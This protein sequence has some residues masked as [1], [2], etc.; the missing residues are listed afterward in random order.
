MKISIEK[1]VFKTLMLAGVFSCALALVSVFS[2]IPAFAHDAITGPHDGPDTTASDAAAGDVDDMK[3]F[4][5]HVRAHVTDPHYGYL[6][7]SEF[8]LALS[9]DGGVFRSGSFYMIALLPTE[10]QVIIHGADKSVEDRRLLSLEDT[11]REDLRML[12]E[13]AKADTDRD[14]VCREY[15][16]D[17]ETR[18]SC[19]LLEAG[20]LLSTG[21]TAIV[22]G[23]DVRGTDLRKLE[24]QDLPGSEVLLDSSADQVETAGDLEAQKEALKSFVHSA[25]DAYYIDFLFKGSCDFSTVPGFESFDLASLS[26]DQIKAFIPQIVSSATGGQINLLN[27]CNALRASLYRS[28]MRSEEGPWKSGSVYVFSMDDNIDVQRVLFNGLDAELE[29]KDPKT[30]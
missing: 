18:T 14:G 13:D 12:I 8:R 15:M 6:T 7:I 4:L 9:E 1:T 20:R 22:V 2:G 25:I 19:A 27:V 28:V 3:N 17:G 10:G 21:D 24:F 5:Q 16:K 29:D 11:E 30:F 23:Y 26:R